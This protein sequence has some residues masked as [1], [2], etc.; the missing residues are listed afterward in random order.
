MS[1]PG[2]EARRPAFPLNALWV[3]EKNPLR[4]AWYPATSALWTF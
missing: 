2:N 1:R 4:G 3:T